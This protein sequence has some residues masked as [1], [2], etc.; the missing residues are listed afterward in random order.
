M[1]RRCLFLV[2]V[3]CGSLW[4]IGCID[5]SPVP[6]EP[7]APRFSLVGADQG[8]VVLRRPPTDGVSYTVRLKDYM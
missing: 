5:G 7:E 2:T 6:T 4:G 8:S 1:L 3:A